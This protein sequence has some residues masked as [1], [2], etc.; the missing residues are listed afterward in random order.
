MLI[1]RS[2]NPDPFNFPSIFAD[3]C[4]MVPVYVTASKFGGEIVRILASP[5]I[6]ERARTQGF[7]VDARA[8][9][10]FAPFLADEVQRWAKVIN[11]AHITVD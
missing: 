5:D 6:E 10:R 9:D 3:A 7:R 1:T 8:A 11:A 2:V 4:D